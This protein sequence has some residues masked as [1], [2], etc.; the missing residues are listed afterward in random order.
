M[1]IIKIRVNYTVI[2]AQMTE[3]PKWK[4]VTAEVLRQKWNNVI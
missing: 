3:A 2:T 4:S 1:F